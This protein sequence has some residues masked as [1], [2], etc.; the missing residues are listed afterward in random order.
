M[1]LLSKI[2][3]PDD[4]R[5]LPIEKLPSLCDEIRGCIIETVTKTGGHLASSL[6]A[7]ELITALH[8]VFHTPEDKIVYDVGH[9]AYTHKILTERR[10]FFHTLRQFKGISGFI[11]PD[12]SIYDTFIS[13]HTGTALSAGL[14]IAKARDLKGASYK[15]IVVIGDGTLTNGMTF[16][17]L[18]NTHKVKNL[19]IVINDNKM[20]ISQNVGAISNYLNRI[21]TSPLYN[22]LKKEL[23]RILERLPRFTERFIEIARK[24]EEALKG[25]L[26]PGILF[27]ELG[28]RYFGPFDG[29]NVIELVNVFQKIKF[30]EQP[31]IIHTI[32]KK[33]KGYP[34][35]EDNAEKF[36]GVSPTKSINSQKNISTEVIPTYTEVFSN[37]ICKLAEMDKNLIAITAA[38]AEGTGLKKF[39]EKFPDRF[40]D[41]G[42]AEEHAVTFAAGLA[43]E[44]IRPIVAIYS[45]FLQRSYDQ[46]I[47]D[48]CLQKL[49]VIF[50]IDRAGLVGEDGPTHHGIFDIAYLRHIPN[51]VIMQPK[52]ENELQHMLYTAWTYRDGPVVVRY[53]RGKG[54]GVPLETVLRKI[55]IGKAELL[56]EG[57]EIALVAVGNMVPIAK[58]VNKLLRR[59]GIYPAVI[60]ARFIKPL[61]E[62]FV[63]TGQEY[64]TIVTLEEHVLSGG[65]GSA[66]MEFLVAHGC[67]NKFLNIGIPDK[68][69]PHGN[70]V[71]LRNMLGLTA[72]SIS[73]K[74]FQFLSI[75][76]PTSRNEQKSKT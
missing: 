61:D 67:S 50:A 63:N 41:V 19:L 5:K 48:V 26:V 55:T 37:T 42:I 10:E 57:K 71:E 52:D 65:F 70:L 24:L 31:V 17:A 20:A 44:G 15:V 35:A 23:E 39:A 51:L 7:V 13:G 40:I 73:S 74:I 66:V 62:T 9:Q 8:Y 11:R 75:G 47:I 28:L 14:G 18:N 34:P 38:M 60:N 27:E 33:G 4:L 1:E 6:G 16:E 43:K 76:L 56:I 45:T 54:T 30:I 53:P 59:Q 58:K 49:P 25:I 12:E 72:E 29:H 22:K 21:I 68:F 36:H 64:S 32:T 2:N 69:V 46:I 3:S